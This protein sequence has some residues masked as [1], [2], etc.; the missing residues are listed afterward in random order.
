[1]LNKCLYGGLLRSFDIGLGTEGLY[2]YVRL[3]GYD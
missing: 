1:M 3:Y 2:Y